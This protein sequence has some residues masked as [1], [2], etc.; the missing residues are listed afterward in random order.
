MGRVLEGIRDLA[1]VVS[2]AAF[3]ATAVQVKAVDVRFSRELGV[4]LSA[5]DVGTG[6]VKGLAGRALGE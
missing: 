2:S 4:K 3:V 1:G 5:V 6:E